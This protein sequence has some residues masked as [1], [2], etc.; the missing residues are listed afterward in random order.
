LWRSWDKRGSIGEIMFQLKYN[1]TP[2]GQ[3]SW[4]FD[5]YYNLYGDPKYGLR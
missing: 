5:H 4:D 3:W 1:T 2:A